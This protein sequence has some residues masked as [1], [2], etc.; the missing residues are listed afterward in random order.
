MNEPLN[1][2]ADI[3]NNIVSAKEATETPNAECRLSTAGLPERFVNFVNHVAEVN[4]VPTELTLLSALTTAGAAI[5]GGIT[6]KVF[7]HENRPCLWTMI[8]AKFSDGK[9]A[10]LRD[11]MR[12]L[13]ELD[14][15]KVYEYRENLKAYKEAEAGKGKNTMPKPRKEQIICGKT[16]GAAREQLLNENPRGAILFRD[17]LRGFL[18][19]LNGYGGT[20]DIEDMLSIYESMPLKVDRASDDDLRYCEHPFMPI[21]GGIQSKVLRESFSKDLLNNGFFARFAVVYF[22]TCEDRLG[23]ELSPDIAN[24]WANMIYKLRDFG[25]TFREFRATAEAQSVYETESIKLKKAGRVPDPAMSEDYNEYKAGAYSKTLY[26]VA[27]LALIAHVLKVVDYG[28]MYP[29][30]DID[31][32]TMR[33]AFSCAPY[34]CAMQMKAY[35]IIA[36]RRED[37][38]LTTDALIRAINRHVTDRHLELNQSELARMLGTSQP[39]VSRALRGEK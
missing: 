36:G 13:Q 38:P 2:Y 10:P 5:G 20:S 9:T 35:D 26:V 29:Y 19:D 15:R 30:P 6:S 7:N 22:D 24:S 1:D 17:E 27:R 18:K 34:L 25:N 21:L 31:A 12:P 33:W 11:I 4:N 32:D 8:V 28:C 16:T 14:K 23:R 39:N 37:K 3:V